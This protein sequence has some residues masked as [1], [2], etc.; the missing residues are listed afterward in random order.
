MAL[1][2]EYFDNINI[3]VVKKKYYNANKVGALLD[4]IRAQAA[5]LSQENELLREQLQQLN[6]QK[7][8]IGDTLMSAQSLAKQIVEQANAKAADIIRNAERERDSLRSEGSAQQEYAV[9]YVENMFAELKQEHEHS[10]EMLNERWQKFLCGL[11]PEEKAAAPAV[12]AAPVVPA[13]PKPLFPED[14]YL[15]PDDLEERVAAIAKELR[16]ILG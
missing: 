8:E 11:M 2:N 12:P 15:D 14:D 9:R 7:S 16:E 1:N 3:E 10:I 5:A 6:N 4:D 13:A